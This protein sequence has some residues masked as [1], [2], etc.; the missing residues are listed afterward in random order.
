M[1]KFRPKTQMLFLGCSMILV[2]LILLGGVM[3]C[4]PG[5]FRLKQ[6]S[7]VLHQSDVAR[8]YLDLLL[9]AASLAAFLVICTRA[10]FRNRTQLTDNS[11]EFGPPLHTKSKRAYLLWSGCFI[12]GLALSV[13]VTY[14]IATLHYGKITVDAMLAVKE[15]ERYK[16]VARASDAYKNESR[17]VAIY[18]LSQH[19]LTL[20][21]A[22]KLPE[23]PFTP[24]THPPWLRTPRLRR[25][26]S[27]RGRTESDPSVEFA[28]RTRCR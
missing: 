7:V 8:L 3:M 5:Y 16:S 23:T 17:P 2:S 28:G 24:Q 19:L 12:L 26:T 10:V 20:E 15:A 27:H 4:L 11:S 18:A 6:G 22:A 13:G 14:F 21:E 9:L 25:A 1:L